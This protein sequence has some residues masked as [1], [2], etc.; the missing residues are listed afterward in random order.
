MSKIIVLVEYMDGSVVKMSLNA[1]G[2]VKQF[3][4]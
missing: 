4:V 2:A 1:I 3:A